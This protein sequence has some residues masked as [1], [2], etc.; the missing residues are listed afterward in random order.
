MIMSKIKKLWVRWLIVA[1]LLLVSLILIFNQQIKEWLITGYQ[2]VVTSQTIAKN[3]RHKANYD[4]KQVNDLSIQNV[5]KARA[6]QKQIN[7]I[8]YLAIPQID[9]KLPIAKGVDNLTLSLAAGTLRE[10]MVMGQ[11]NYALAGHNMAHDSRVLFSPLYYHARVGQKI[12]LTDF[13][14]IYEYRVDQRRFIKATDVQV[15]DDT[16][17]PVI[18]LVTCDETG[19][20][21]LMIRGSL[22]KIK[23]F[24][25][26]SRQLQRLFT[27]DKFNN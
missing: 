22:V 13:K 1:L 14:K 18:T 24:A 26:S 12:Y 6:S 11:G 15:I 3:Q 21:R 4:F 9:L 2:P 25:R 17:Q 7:V 8:G 5:I 16:R 10:K 19:Q 27:N 20:G 23:S